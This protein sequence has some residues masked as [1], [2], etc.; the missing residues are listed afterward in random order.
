MIIF[1][2]P[3]LN[4]CAS[5]FS[6]HWCNPIQA[7]A[8]SHFSPAHHSHALALLVFFAMG[9]TT[10][11]TIRNKCCCLFGFDFAIFTTRRKRRLCVVHASFWGWRSGFKWVIVRI[12]SASFCISMHHSLFKWPAFQNINA[13]QNSPPDSGAYAP[14]HELAI[15][16]SIHTTTWYH[17]RSSV[18]LIVKFIKCVRLRAASDSF[19]I[20]MWVLELLVE[21]RW[22]KLSKFSW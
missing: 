12:M 2:S 22:R 7:S 14:G 3:N 20:E 15:F 1:P 9:I 8:M 19:F 4:V 6:K 21:K 10:L 16:S 18:W 17:D 5:K 11:P 13:T